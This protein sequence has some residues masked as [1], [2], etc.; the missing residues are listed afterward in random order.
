M[1]LLIFIALF[2]GISAIIKASKDREYRKRIRSIEA[3]QRENT[4]KAE[5]EAVRIAELEREAERH[6]V[7]LERHET[8][9]RKHDEQISKL[10]FKM[11]QAE[12]DIEHWKWQV[13]NLYAL[14][15]IAQNELEEA[16]TG[17]KNQIKY[18]KQIITLNNQIRAAEKRMETAQFTIENSRRKM[19]A[20]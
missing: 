4:R 16:I 17:G 3:I 18:Q 8:E 12:K 6:A 1:T 11:Q 20:A 13:G 14:L 19:E 5:A 10:E 15:D 7:V 9:T 2:W